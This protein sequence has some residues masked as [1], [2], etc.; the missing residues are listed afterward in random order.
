MYE[1]N[2][3]LLAVVDGDTV[4]LEIDLGFHIR[5]HEVFR[6]ARI[7]AP[8]LL[9]IEGMQARQF[10]DQQLAKAT[11][12]KCQTSRQEKYGRWLCELFIQTKESGSEWVNVNT[13]MLETRHA[14]PFKH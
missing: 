11:A 1:Y 7:N 8:E 9:S 4:K 2:C 6:L 14:V 3:T 13:L 5:V 12:M 10:I